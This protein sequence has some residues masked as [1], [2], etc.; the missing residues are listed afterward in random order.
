[1]LK[2]NKNNWKAAA[3]VLLI[4]SCAMLLP[5]LGGIAL[6]DPDEPVY[7]QT[8]KE[9]LAAGDLLSPR[10]YGDYWYDKPPMYYWLVALSFQLLGVSELA[11]RLP[12]TISALACVMLVFWQVGKMRG[13]AVGLLS[14]LVLVSSFEFFYL[15]KGA[16][17]DST[18]NLFITAA[19]LAF[20][21]KKYLWC[22]VFAGLATLTKGPIGLVFPLGIGALYLCVSRQG[23]ELLNPRLY[24]GLAIYAAI[25][26][27]WY[28]AMYNVHGMAFIET[29]LG[30]HNLTRFTTPEHPGTNVWYFFPSVFLIGF[31]PWSLLLP[32]AAYRFVKGREGWG[33]LNQDRIFFLVWA[34]AVLLFFSL[35]KTKLVSYILPMFPPMAIL[36][37][38]YLKEWIADEAATRNWSL[39]FLMTL[40]AAAFSWNAP[41][42]VEQLPQLA[43]GAG[44]WEALFWSMAVWLGVFSLRKRKQAVV[45]VLT[46]GMI[47][48]AAVFVGVMVPAVEGAFSCKAFVREA[49]RTVQAGELVYVAKFLRPGYT[50]YA[51]TTSRELTTEQDFRV[52]L[53]Q[54]ER[55]YYAV[56]QSFYDRL[57]VVEK[58]QLR[59]VVNKDGKLLL[60]R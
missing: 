45:A 41:R 19:L 3:V 47:V 22:Y 18:L 23:R 34:L 32:A 12:S 56:P 51:D 24:W 50:F 2:R 37:G 4:V 33:R 25:A 54:Q 11:A 6:L 31:F 28:V 43:Y 44:V 30:F 13:V 21:R 27:P 49:Q 9:M 26:A 35:S 17:T 5:N 58:G 55:A 60:H 40:L 10:I 1:M 38:C 48:F 42:G 46:A 36:M 8:A 29:F 57:S 53:Q 52:A 7:G 59:I 14:G 20:W 15:A 16:V 39:P